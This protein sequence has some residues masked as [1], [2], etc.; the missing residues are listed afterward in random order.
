MGSG[1][2]SD[3]FSK[4]ARLLDLL[5]AKLRLLSIWRK[6]NSPQRFQELF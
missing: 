2:P 4:E 3:S 6:E 5:L 1:V